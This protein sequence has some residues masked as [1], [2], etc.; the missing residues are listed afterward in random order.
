MPPYSEGVRAKFDFVITRLFSRATEIDK[1]VCL[2][3][4]NEMLTH[5]GKLYSEWSSIPLYDAE[6]D[7]SNVMLT[8][9]SF[10]D[11]ALEAESVSNFDQLIESDFFGR[12]R[13]FKESINEL[14]YEPSVTVSA[15]ASNIRIGNAYVDLILK[16]R[17]KMDA[18]SIQS[19]YGE[20]SEQSGPVS[21]AAGQTLDL[22]GLLNVLTD[23]VIL[24]QQN[25]I[26]E[27]KAAEAASA[28]P[29]ET[30]PAPEKKVEK[31]R[32]PFVQRMIDNV[33]GVN[34]VL[35]GVCLLLAMATGGLYVW[36]TYI[37]DEQVSSAGVIKVN[38]ENS[39]IN[40][41]VKTGRISGETFY[42]LLGPSWD[43]L[44]KEKREEFL[45]T[46]MQEGP[47]RG[48]KQ[49]NLIAKDGKTAG[50]ASPTRVE[51]FMP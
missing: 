25:A 14:F 20:F 9:L 24:A 26:A 4:R 39:P 18:E 22:C 7:E 30:Q 43:A 36:S 41:H 37:V 11:L 15:I 1:R 40:E 33:K 23:D 3:D 10:D 32:S 42:G 28:T 12:L 31:A 13:Q 35:V 6:E 34:K 48:Y 8:G 50:F 27:A 2:F 44:P 16:E 21:D 46:I 51:V 45:Q 5:I 47:E 17:Q 19:K 49:V 38:L 29:P